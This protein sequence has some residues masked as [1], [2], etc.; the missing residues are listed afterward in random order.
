MS[1]YTLQCRSCP[2]AILDK[3]RIGPDVEKLEH[4]EMIDE[5]Y[6]D[7]VRVEISLGHKVLFVYNTYITSVNSQPIPIQ[8]HIKDETPSLRYNGDC[9]IV[10]G[11]LQPE[12]FTVEFVD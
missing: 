8:W 1:K 12:D 10:R 5:P 6:W 2:Q 4:P 9:L 7:R 11:D 3:A